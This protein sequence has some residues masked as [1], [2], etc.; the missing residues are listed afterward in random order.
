MIWSDGGGSGW[1]GGGGAVAMLGGRTTPAEHDVG[2]G[3]VG[4]AGSADGSLAVVVDAIGLA[5]QAL[6]ARGQWPNFRQQHV[7]T[8]QTHVYATATRWLRYR[9]ASRLFFS[10]SSN[11]MGGPLLA[12]EL[13]GL[14]RSFSVRWW[15][16]VCAYVRNASVSV[17]FNRY[18]KW[19]Y[20]YA[21]ESMG[22]KLVRREMDNGT[23]F[24]RR[25]RRIYRWARRRREAAGR[26]WGRCSA[27]RAACGGP[28][29][30]AGNCTRR[31]PCSLCT[32]RNGTG[33]R[34]PPYRHVRKPLRCRPGDRRW[35]QW[36]PTT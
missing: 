16:L 19:C 33:T 11:W 2:G 9:Q 29:G 26:C 22:M 14:V 28:D 32:S 1:G 27:R 5:G 17:W 12:I 21:L 23:H 36:I 3:V 20:L 4:G 24:G 30:T 35:K 15:Q 31:S 10:L 8:D 7:L 18:F 34:S 13:L 25:S 6:E